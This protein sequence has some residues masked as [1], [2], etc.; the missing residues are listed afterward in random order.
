[1]IGNELLLSSW[2]FMSFIALSWLTYEDFTNKRRLGL[3]YWGVDDRKNWY[4]MG[5]TTLVALLTPM[6]VWVKLG[7]LLGAGVITGFIS[8]IKYFGSA[9]TRS[10]GWLLIGWLMLGFGV[11]FLILLL[12]LLIVYGL[13]SKHSFKKDLPFFIFL[14]LLQVI[15]AFFYYG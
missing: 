4:M 7:L 5:V 8:N 3:D 6:N 9:D 12:F 2:L 10:I 15:T 1:M 14:L 11:Q 13:L